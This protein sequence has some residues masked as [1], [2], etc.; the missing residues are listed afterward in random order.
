MED[1][2]GTVWIPSL[3][4]LYRFANGRLSHEGATDRLQATAIANDAEGRLWVGTINGPRL[5]S[6]G[7]I[8]EN[9]VTRRIPGEI[10]AMS[11]D[12]DGNLWIGAAG[13]G[14]YRVAGQEVSNFSSVDGLGDN[15]VLSLFEDREGSV[16]VG[17]ASG[18][19]RFRNTRLQTLT[20]HEGLPSDAT[21]TLLVARDGSVYVFCAGR[22]LAHIR[23]GAV[24]IF[25]RNEG[26]A[27]VY[28]DHMFESRDGSI[29][30]GT[31]NGLTRFRN[32]GFEVFTAHG[33]LSR[34]YLSAIGEDDEGL[35]VATSEPMVFRFK[36]G[37]VSPLTFG[38]KSTPLSVPGTYIFT[39]HKDA[40]GTLWFGGVKGLYRFRAGEPM[41][42]ARQEQVNFPVTAIY[43]DAEGNLWLGGRVPGLTRFRVA[44]G[45][46]TRYTSKD[47]L[48][49]GYPS[50]MLADTE[51]KLWISTENGL[52]V[53]G[54]K[55][56]DDFA[57]GRIANVPS[58]RYDTRDGMQTA[59]ASRPAAQPAGGRTP[60]GRL[61]FT[62]QKGVVI[63]DPAHLTGNRMIPPVVLEEIV[64]DGQSGP[65][66]PGMHIGP[67]VDRLQFHYTSLS[68]LV[69]GRVQF[70]FKLE[71]YDRDWVEAG[72]R[73][74]AYYTKLPPGRYQFKVLGSNDDGLWNPAAA[75]LTFYL[76]PRFYE[77]GW[78]YGLCAAMV[79]L[80]G[81]TA[82]KLHSRGLRKRADCLARL[83]EVRTEELLEAK[84]VAE[85]ANRSKSEFLA[86][87]SHEIR[88]PMNGVLGMADLLLLSALSSEQRADVNTLRTSA[89]SLLN[90]INDILDFSKIEAHRLD[91]DNTEL[92]L[93]DG[94][95]EAVQ[96]LGFNAHE[97]GLELLC[98]IAPDVPETVVGDRLRL[99]QIVLNLVA[100]AVK[101]TEVGEVAISVQV[102][103]AG[104]GDV[105]LHFTV[106]DTGIGIPTEK[107]EAIFGAF[108]QADNSTTRK[109]GGTGLGLT[110]SSRLVSAMGGRMWLESEPRKGSRF[111]FTAKF[112]QVPG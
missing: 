64:V 109:Y 3:T 85:N 82:H 45:R 112:R 75:T 36:D 28:S 104:G 68:M 30:L 52:W 56:L 33:R 98:T 65:P 31:N 22:G 16:W 94:I 18:L 44:D 10:S 60:D 25:T 50:A 105:V 97:K 72:S 40:A 106:S 35:I 108:A 41:E 21:E 38:G 99:R 89:E 59:E 95:E 96:S 69:P 5:F 24:T 37:E 86:N 103:A 26:L 14:L 80:C 110:I 74:V 32:G 29:W 13:S 63:A 12:R 17:T 92:D 6:G 81:I 53:A 93:R 84:D 101:F 51:G 58:T 83:V 4:G 23:N 67:G 49:D 88:T 100:N 66:R 62:T 87:M 9:D 15:R 19:E 111:H 57:E 42:N 73:R 8:R 71:G 48:F 77:T 34:H 47:G 1:R 90:L 61:W 102:D 107:H 54:R 2:E 76:Q 27:G 55:E 39:I 78:F 46:V 7:A 91:L 43:D 20:H 70:R 79:L 11:P